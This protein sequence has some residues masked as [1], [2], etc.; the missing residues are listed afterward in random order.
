MK[1]ET[2]DVTTIGDNDLQM[3]ARTKY[4][5][6]RRAIRES[7]DPL[8]KDTDDAILMR[9]Y[10]AIARGRRVLHLQQV[11][12]E[13]GL[14]TD[15]LPKLAIARADAAHCT[16]IMRWHGG[17]VFY[18]ERSPDTW[19]TAR[20]TSRT[21]VFPEGTFQRRP[22]RDEHRGWC[23]APS[24]PPWARP[25]HKLENY[26]LLWEAAWQTVP[27]DPMLLQHV[28]GEMFAV[29]AQWD[30]TPLERAVLRGRL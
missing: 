24:I 26:H 23:V 15:W 14:R 1:L 11:M 9:S 29:L 21:R 27:V 4:L 7:T 10:R 12:N 17:A 28:G 16:V 25:R 6:Y 20:T 19:R 3:Q 30:L 5:E 22:S 13:T 2:V 18:S 8:Q